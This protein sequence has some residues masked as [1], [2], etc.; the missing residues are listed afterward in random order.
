MTKFL[1]LAVMCSLAFPAMAF[2]QPEAP[3]VEEDVEM[4]MGETTE[5]AAAEEPT[6]TTEE[7]AA[8]EPTE[9]A[10]YAQP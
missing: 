4:G 2:A 5:G 10:L 6:E 3:K 7:A 1:P 9:E 8:E